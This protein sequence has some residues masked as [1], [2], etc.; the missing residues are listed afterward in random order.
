MNPHCKLS[1]SLLRTRCFNSVL[2]TVTWFVEKAVYYAVCC[3][4]CFAVF[5]MCVFCLRSVNSVL[6]WRWQQKCIV[7]Y[8]Y[9]SNCP[10]LCE[11]WTPDWD[12]VWGVNFGG[13]RNLYYG[14][15]PNPTRKRALL[16]VISVGH[17]RC[18][19]Q[20]GGSGATSGYQY[21]SNLLYCVT[22]QQQRASKR[23]RV[24]P[25]PSVET[26][27]VPKKKPATATSRTLQQ[28]RMTRQKTAAAAITT[29]RPAATSRAP[30]AAAAKPPPAKGAF[31]F[32]LVL[33]ITLFNFVW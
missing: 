9:C 1:C 24:E 32:F 28:S 17:A 20:G 7:W 10:P 18:C 6:Y 21:C 14:W 3:Y 29:A 30:P 4:Q 22:V 5:C 13:S 27:A 16:E 26:T 31:I 23:Q 25:A 12:V 2:Q 33:K 19:F 15:G 8:Q 11:C